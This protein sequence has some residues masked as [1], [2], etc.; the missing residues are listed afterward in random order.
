MVNGGDRTIRKSLCVEFGSGFGSAII[1]KAN[2]ISAYEF[3]PARAT[4]IK[5]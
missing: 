5:R 3:F 2:Y 4:I 1:P